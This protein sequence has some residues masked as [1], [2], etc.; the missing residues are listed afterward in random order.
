ME[1]VRPEGDPPESHYIVEDS[2]LI[3][4]ILLS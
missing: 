4:E 1:V 3:T 2:S